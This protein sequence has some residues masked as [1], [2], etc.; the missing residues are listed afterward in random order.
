LLVVGAAAA[1]LGRS[2][3]LEPVNVL[4]SSV[5]R[6]DPTTQSVVADVPV[7]DPA[8]APMIF[9]SP[10]QVWVL[11][12]RQQII[13]VIDT[14]TNSV[15]APVPIGPG[16][17]AGP[18]G[19]V[20]HSGMVQAFE[21]VYVTPIDSPRSVEK[22]DPVARVVI[23]PPLTLTGQTGDLASGD[24]ALWVYVRDGNTAH[25]EAIRPNGHPRCR[26]RVGNGPTNVAYGQKA[27]WLSDHLYFTVTKVDPATCQSSP[28]P[29]TGASGEP[30]GIGFGFGFVWVSDSL[31]G[32]VY[33]IDPAT[34]RVMDTIPVSGPGSGYLS[35][36]VELDGSMW[37]ASPDA[38]MIEQIDPH[39]NAVVS[40]INLPYAP[41]SLLAANGSLWATVTQFPS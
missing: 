27:V 10:N 35:D 34:L 16:E 17:A 40:R 21:G 11:S 9:L 36:V 29:M 1:Y 18:V 2:K 28:V 24:G 5:V 7:A 12:Q 6:I 25:V 3:P 39:T 26:G 20:S 22:I 14:N 30:T 19:Q 13:S 41:Q 23:P 33:K 38:D 37:V 31:A 32:V 15:S 8:A 4:P